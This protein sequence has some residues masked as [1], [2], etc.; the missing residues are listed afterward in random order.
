QP[1][2]FLEAHFSSRRARPCDGSRLSPASWVTSGRPQHH[3]T[4]V[5]TGIKPGTRP[6]QPFDE[7]ETCPAHDRRIDPRDPLARAVPQPPHV[8]VDVRFVP[9]LPELRHPHV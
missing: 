7:R 6:T 3:T 1:W 5:A 2:L 9:Q 4:T 8:A